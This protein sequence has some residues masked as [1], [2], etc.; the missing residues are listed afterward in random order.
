MIATKQKM[1][2]LGIDGGS[3]VPSRMV[4]GGIERL[5]DAFIKSLAHLHS[6]DKSWFYYFFSNKKE[7]FKNDIYS[8]KQIPEKLYSTVFLPLYIFFDKIDIYLGFSGVLPQLIRVLKKKSIIFIHD[9][10]FY[11]TPQNYKDPARMR[12]Q[13]EYA[14][15]G[16][17]KIVV[18]SD[19]IKKQ[20][21]TRFPTI[22]K[23]K[24]V[25][26][27]P[28]SDHIKKQYQT[29]KNK[30]LYFLYVGVIK[31]AKNIMPSMFF[32]A[33]KINYSRQMK[34]NLDIVNFE[35]QV[36]DHRTVS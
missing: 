13:T 12:W 25:R 6:T 31:K 11:E 35:I 4:R 21:F 7:N 9:L 23:E 1:I 34:Q 5:V 28:G 8:P 14:L 26:I 18:F 22:R 2:R 33:L 27:Y 17:D 30:G 15:F 16:S 3:L 20:I 19:H 36:I 32:T 24:V 10:A 29:I